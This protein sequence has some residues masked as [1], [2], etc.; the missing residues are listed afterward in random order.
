MRLWSL[1]PRYLD[2]QGLTAAWREALL[3]Q[4][5]LAGRT[6]GYRSHPQLR[7]FACTSDPMGAI[8]AY[9]E[10]LADEATGRGYRYDRSRIDRP[11][12]GGDG[13]GTRW[14][15]AIEATTGQVEYEWGHL[16]AKLRLRSPD[17]LAGLE[18]R[19]EAADARCEAHPVFRVIEGPVAD[20]E[21]V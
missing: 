18:T 11:T 21:V 4:A 1:H 13:T 16:D 6:K 19:C 5:V 9:L 12:T 10:A 14:D 8:G 20:W 7:R 3:A 15:G 2:R 17:W